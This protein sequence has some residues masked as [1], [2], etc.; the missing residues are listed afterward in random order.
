MNDDFCCF[1]CGRVLPKSECSSEHIIPACLG[2]TLDKTG[3]RLVCKD[4][5]TK[6]GK[7]V[8]LPFCRDWII[9]SKRFFEG[10]VSRG[11]RPSTKVGRINWERPE[12]V[13]VY[14]LEHK[15]IA[16][17]FRITSGESCVLFGSIGQQATPE[18][19]D[20]V[21]KSL[22]DRFSN[23][24]VI[25]PGTEKTDQERDVIGA[26]EA[27]GR[28]LKLTMSADVTAWDRAVVKMGL[29]LSCL[30]FGEEF[31]RS[32]QADHLRSFLW[33]SDPNKRDEIPLHGSAGFLSQKE[34][35]LSRIFHEDKGVH[36]FCLMEI[37]SKIGFFAGFFGEFENYLEVDSVGTFCGRLPGA[38]MRGAVWIVDP[39]KKETIGPVPLEELI[40]RRTEERHRTLE[41]DFSQVNQSPKD[42]KENP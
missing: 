29:G 1:Y 39:K 26:I 41:R 19:V 38:L 7:D 10:V 33:E 17:R 6:A 9:E 25:N 18:A 21:K 15:V 40:Q 31:A 3:T 27:M 30:Y 23:H 20:V 36:T 12:Q 42:L 16:Y 35:K 4:C 37:G 32:Q 2:A 34:S 11:K 13:E 24:R 8:D 5:N 14:F 28:N 22:K